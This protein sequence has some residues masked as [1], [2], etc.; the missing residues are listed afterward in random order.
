MDKNKPP[1][2][3]L[4]S[5]DKLKKKMIIFKWILKQVSLKGNSNAKLV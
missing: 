3:C 5:V 2:N 1:L 4:Q